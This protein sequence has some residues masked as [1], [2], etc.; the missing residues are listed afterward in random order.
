MSAATQ[1]LFSQ[2]ETWVLRGISVVTAI[3]L[4][5]MYSFPIAPS[6]ETRTFKIA[7]ASSHALTSAEQTRLVFLLIYI[8]LWR[9]FSFFV[10]LK[11]KI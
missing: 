2:A 9:E 6:P 7:A 3:H 8:Y 5:L 1:P 4:S 11:V 10:P